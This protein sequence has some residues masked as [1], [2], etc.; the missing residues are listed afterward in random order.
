MSAAV[1]VR[2]MALSFFWGWWIDG[3][4]PDRPDLFGAALCAVA[5][6]VIMYWPRAAVG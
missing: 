2:S 4:A 6:A 3:C 5:V 1:V